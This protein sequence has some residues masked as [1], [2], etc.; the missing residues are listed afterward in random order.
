MLYFVVKT[1]AS[2][3][4]ISQIG[5]C[6]A[7]FFIA[8]WNIFVSSFSSSRICWWKSK[9]CW[10][11]WHAFNLDVCQ[12]LI[13]IVHVMRDVVEHWI[14]FLIN[15]A[16]NRILSF[17]A[18]IVLIKKINLLQIAFSTIDWIGQHALAVGQFYCYASQTKIASE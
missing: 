8:L 16:N 14:I 6:V 1:V 7:I 13:F 12:F 17:F 3:Q 18:L 10:C 9:L 2:S 5:K 4:L 11:V 15:V